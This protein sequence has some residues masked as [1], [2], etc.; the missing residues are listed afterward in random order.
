M[1]ISDITGLTNAE[2]N[3]LKNLG[4]KNIANIGGRQR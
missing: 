2:I 4:A 3:T 1:N